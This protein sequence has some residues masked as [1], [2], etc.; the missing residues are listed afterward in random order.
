VKDEEFCLLRYNALQSV[1]IKPP[2]WKNMS[3]LF[4]ELKSEPSKKPVPSKQQANFALQH[5]PLKRQLTFS[6]LQ[7]VTSQRRE[8]FK[9]TS[10]RTSDPTF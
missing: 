9:S 2:F 10:V 7:G 8:L 3:P 4:L 6:E 5:V 1:E